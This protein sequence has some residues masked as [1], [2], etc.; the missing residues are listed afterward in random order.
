ME[1]RSKV[2]GDSWEAEQLRATAALRQREEIW[3]KMFERLE[4]KP[5]ALDIDLH[6][7]RF[8]AAMGGIVEWWGDYVEE[9]H[10]M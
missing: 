5:Y 3:L 1:Y 8:D 6:Y 2:H 4:R 10:R 7:C 9:R